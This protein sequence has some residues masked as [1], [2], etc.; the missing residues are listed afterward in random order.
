MPFHLY[1]QTRD[2]Y[3]RIHEN[4]SFLSPMQVYDPEKQKNVPTAPERQGQKLER[5]EPPALP[6]QKAQKASLVQRYDPSIYY[7][8]APSIP[9]DDHEQNFSPLS[10]NSFDGHRRQ[11]THS[12]EDMH[13]QHKGQHHSI[14]SSFSPSARKVKHN[15]N[16]PNQVAQ[17]FRYMDAE[18]KREELMVY[19]FWQPQP[20][21]TAS[22][23]KKPQRD[24]KTH[25][26]TGVINMEWHGKDSD[27]GDIQE[28]FVPEGPPVRYDVSSSRTAD[29]T[30][31][32]QTL[33]DNMAANS[34]PQEE[35][36][37]F[38][39]LDNGMPAPG[40]VPPF[41]ERLKKFARLQQVGGND[42]D[43]PMWL[44]NPRHQFIA[45][46]FRPER[47]DIDPPHKVEE[48]KYIANTSEREANKGIPPSIFRKDMA[49]HDPEPV[50]GYYEHLGMDAPFEEHA[51]PI[52]DPLYYP[53]DEGYSDR[54]PYT[55]YKRHNSYGYG[56]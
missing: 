8:N 22:A 38:N 3:G 4:F 2:E 24:R 39:K 55:N 7:Q 13:Y 29:V 9:A 41:A 52:T 21:Q 37:D 34:L 32:P 56:G 53:I 1:L 10:P 35:Q 48:E 36:R 40:A 5:Y 54:E 15:V 27:D 16:G 20:E 6:E 17:G 25:R 51:T 31:E 49:R 11:P 14:P 42:D 44:E 46:D 19:D 23:T 18:P 33:H 47:N 12:N 26:D 50:Q 43:D 45:D 28:D 30:E